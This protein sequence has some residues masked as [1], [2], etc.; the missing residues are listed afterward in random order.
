MPFTDDMWLI[1]VL[2]KIAPSGIWSRV[3]PQIVTGFFQ[4]TACILHVEN[5]P[6]GQKKL[7]NTQTHIMA[8]IKSN[9]VDIYFLVWSLSRLL[10]CIGFGSSVAAALDRAANGTGY[11]KNIDHNLHND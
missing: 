5:K 4:R 2:S 11:G 7:K 6:R 3:A 1:L 8:D 10:C 9:V